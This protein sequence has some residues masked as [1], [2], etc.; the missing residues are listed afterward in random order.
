MCMDWSTRKN[1]P[2]KLNHSR[3]FLGL[4]FLENLYCKL[5][6]RYKEP[7]TALEE[8]PPLNITF[9]ECA[10]LQ[11]LSERVGRLERGTHTPNI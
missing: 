9:R 1:I 8:V 4:R 10:S 2:R 7:R 3:T 5:V 11:L 6:S